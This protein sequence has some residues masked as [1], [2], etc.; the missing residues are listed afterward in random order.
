MLVP[1]IKLGFSFSV[2]EL[3]GNSLPNQGGQTC[4]AAPV[5]IITSTLFTSMLLMESRVAIKRFSRVLIAWITGP[6]LLLFG[7]R[8]GGAG[9][10]RGYCCGW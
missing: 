3:S 7:F 6:L 8:C 5:S 2:R 9:S 10:A 4:V 1:E